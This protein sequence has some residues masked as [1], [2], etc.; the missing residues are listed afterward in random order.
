M[1]ANVFQLK[2]MVGQG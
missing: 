2:I 1:S